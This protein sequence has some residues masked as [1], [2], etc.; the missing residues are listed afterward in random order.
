MLAACSRQ[1]IATL[2]PIQV[3]DQVDDSALLGISIL[4][5]EHPRQ[6]S[7]LVWHPVGKHVLNEAAMQTV[8]QDCHAWHLARHGCVT[9][10]S[11]H[12]FLGFYEPASAQ[13]WHQGSLVQA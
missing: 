4:T 8:P 13:A 10:S 7:Q 5:H 1:D 2:Q 9:A 6:S 12:L 11:R 3:A